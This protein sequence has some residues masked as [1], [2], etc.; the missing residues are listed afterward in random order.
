MDSDKKKR[1]IDSLAEVCVHVSSESYEKSS[2]FAVLICFALKFAV[3]VG[4][5]IALRNLAG[6]EFGELWMAVVLAYALYGHE[7][8]ISMKIKEDLVKS[9][10]EKEDYDE[11]KDTEDAL[12][13]EGAEEEKKS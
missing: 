9:I 8:F 1:L 3:A 5:Y 10:L 2:R 7:Q 11:K 13:L 12:N 4:A 6:L